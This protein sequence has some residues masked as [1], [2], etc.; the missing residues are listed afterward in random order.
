[1]LS[2]Q[3]GFRAAPAAEATISQ[4]PSVQGNQPIGLVRSIPLF[5][6]A[7]VRIRALKLRPIILPVRRI[8]RAAIL[9]THRIISPARGWRA[10]HVPAGALGPWSLLIMVRPWPALAF[11]VRAAVTGQLRTGRCAR[12]RRTR[13]PRCPS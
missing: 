5:A 6:P 11:R 12:P 9:S 3:A 8:R 13:V 4:L 2:Y 10:P 1:M 7:V